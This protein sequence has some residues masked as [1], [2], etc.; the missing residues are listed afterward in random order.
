MLN[1]TL[2]Q[3]RNRQ[4]HQSR[5]TRTAEERRLGERG[6]GGAGLVLVHRRRRHSHCPAVHRQRGRLPASRRPL[7]HAAPNPTGDPEGARVVGCPSGAGAEG[8][9]QQRSAS[10]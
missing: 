7:A 6:A 9:R 3:L 1:G 4:W 5:R 10:L 8:S 2:I